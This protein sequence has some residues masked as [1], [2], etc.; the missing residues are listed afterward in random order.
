MAVRVLSCPKP[1]RSS[2]LGTRSGSTKARLGAVV[3]E[4]RRRPGLLLQ[5]TEARDKGE[6]VRVEKGLNFPTT[7]LLSSNPLTS[8]DLR[9][10]DAVAP[11]ADLIGYSFVQRPEDIADC[12]T[13][14]PPAEPPAWG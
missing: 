10:L 4:A 7:D 13:S 3:K 11:I 1:S 2:T 5:V 12:R 6:H 14:S 9:D 8:D